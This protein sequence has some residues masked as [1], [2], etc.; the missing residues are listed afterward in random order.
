VIA[1]IA[2]SSLSP[3]GEQLFTWRP[4]LGINIVLGTVT[5][6]AAPRTLPADSNRGPVDVLGAG[7]MGGFLTR[8]PSVKAARKLT[9]PRR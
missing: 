6:L 4:V 3:L 2:T 1:A 8:R 9:P 5:L 7:L